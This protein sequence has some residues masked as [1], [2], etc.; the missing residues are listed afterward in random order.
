[1]RILSVVSLKTYERY[2]YTFLKE[3]VLRRADYNEY[4]ISKADFKKLYPND[5]E[6]M[7]L[8]YLQ[9][10][11]NHLFGVDE[12]YLFN[13][14]NLWIRNI[15]IKKRVEDLQIGIE[16]YQT[17]L[18]L[19]QPDCDASDFLFKEYYTIISKPRAVIY[20]DRNEQKMMMR[21]TE[22][23][24][25]SDG[26]LNRI[27]DKLDHMVKD[28]KLFKYMKTR[29]CSDDDKRGSK[30]FMDVIERGLKIRRIFMSLE[31]FVVE[32]RS[33][34]RSL[35]PKRTIESRAKRS[36]N[37]L[38]RILYYFTCP[39]HNVKTRIIIR[40]IRII[41]VEVEKSVGDVKESKK[42]KRKKNKGKG[43]LIENTIRSAVKNA[44]YDDDF[45]FENSRLFI[46]RAAEQTE[47][48]DDDIVFSF[49]KTIRC[50]QLPM[51]FYEDCLLE[52]NYRTCCVM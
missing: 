42:T 34:L 20:K 16:S 7:Y 18:N 17:K 27:L 10:Q 21:E 52:S 11:L 40:F 28:F 48:F 30:E 1:M 8:L 41:L 50:Y 51:C 26:T 3:I 43:L 38:T 35:K 25:F 49:E 5:F 9:G 23:H 31:S 39:S 24:K 19:T 47:S 45:I 2:G 32:V 36:S 29:I 15:V 22:V 12:V 46:A 44:E 4:K 6:D 37:N 33:S 13:A 14:V